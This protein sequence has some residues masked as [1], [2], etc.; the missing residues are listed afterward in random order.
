MSDDEVPRITIFCADG[1][2]LRQGEQVPRHVVIATFERVT[3]DDYGTPKED[4]SQELCPDWEWLEVGAYSV[5]MAKYVAQLPEP[6]PWPRLQRSPGYWTREDREAVNAYQASLPPNHDKPGARWAGSVSRNY[7]LEQPAYPHRP[8]YRYRFEC[9]L[10][11][12]TVVAKEAR[13][14][15]LLEKIHEAGVASISLAALA[16]RLQ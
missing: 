3:N 4:Y 6:L 1:G 12:R 7:R 16:S 8:A 14:T 15:S 10:C 13:L 5:N 2:H 9:A 11:H